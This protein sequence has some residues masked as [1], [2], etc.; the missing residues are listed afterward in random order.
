MLHLRFADV[1]LDE[2]LGR[3]VIYLSFEEAL[4]QDTRF[5]IGAKLDCILALDIF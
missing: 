2:I 3:V 1:R 5:Y 4:Y